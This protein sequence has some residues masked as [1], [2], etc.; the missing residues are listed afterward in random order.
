MGRF[1]FCFYVDALYIA[2]GCTLVNE[3]FAY[4]SL[5]IRKMRFLGVGRGGGQSCVGW[6]G[7]FGPPSLWLAS[8]ARRVCL[9]VL[10]QR[11]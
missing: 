3:Q 7:G 5:I 9:R 4:R 10:R 6:I 8:A 11:G 1:R 2:K